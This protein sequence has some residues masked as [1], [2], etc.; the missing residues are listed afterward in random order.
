MKR[1]V[2][3]VILIVAFSAQAQARNIIVDGFSGQVGDSAYAAIGFYPRQ[4]GNDGACVGVSSQEEANYTWTNAI[5]DRNF[6][7]NVSADIHY[8]LPHSQPCCVDER[9]I[10]TTA[11]D[12][13]L[14]FSN[15]ANTNDGLFLG[16]EGSLRSKT[17]KT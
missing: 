14:S 4:C 6:I 1:I 15:Y 13:L 3:G 2:V 7:H 10:S 12:T 5:V 9:W 16:T 11:F 8:A 17:K